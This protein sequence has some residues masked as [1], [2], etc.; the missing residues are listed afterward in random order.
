MNSIFPRL[1][2]FLSLFLSSFRSTISYFAIQVSIH[3]H[4]LYSFSCKATAK[5]QDLQYKIT[6][7]EEEIRSLQLKHEFELEVAKK[8][9]KCLQQEKDSIE[10][11]L[12]IAKQEVMALKCTV[13]KMTADSMGITTELQATKV[14]LVFSGVVHYLISIYSCLLP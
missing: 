14:G 13:A 9:K 12:N 4:S 10:N 11:E 8:A 1:S 2:F 6:T 7:A 3:I 5:I